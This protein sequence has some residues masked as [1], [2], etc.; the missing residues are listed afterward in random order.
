MYENTEGFF[1]VIYIS[2]A[3][4]YIFFLEGCIYLY[5]EDRFYREEKTKRDLSS[6]GSIPKWLQWTELSQSN[7]RNLLQISHTGT[8]FQGLT[9]SSAV[10]WGNKQGAGAEME[11][12]GHEPVPMWGA[13][14]TGRGLAFS[15]CFLSFFIGQ[16]F[17]SQPKLHIF[18]ICIP[19][20]G[21]Y[22]SSRTP[23][24]CEHIKVMELFL[25]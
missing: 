7:S 5:L 22:K 21:L 16:R 8:E 18:H 20:L 10:F 15:P 11:L 25:K 13:G 3:L 17:D 12:L 2:E 19:H 9:T 6:P 4:I 14:T 24:V 23:R 1:Q